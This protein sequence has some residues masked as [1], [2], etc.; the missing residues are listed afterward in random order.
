MIYEELGLEIDKRKIPMIAL[1][2]DEALKVFMEWQNK[3]DKVE[4]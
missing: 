1:G 4:Y 3:G 2:R